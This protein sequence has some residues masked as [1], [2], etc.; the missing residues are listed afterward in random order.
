MDGMERIGGIDSKDSIENWITC[1]HTRKVLK[2]AGIDTME[3][4]DKMTE[5]QIRQLKGVGP[6]ISG[7]LE[8][9]VTEWRKRK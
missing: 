2:R 3:Q 1:C 8:K 7:D 5:D 6:V 4:L 9:I